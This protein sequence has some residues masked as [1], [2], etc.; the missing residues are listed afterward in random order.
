MNDIKIKKPLK[1]GWGNKRCFVIAAPEKS[2]R[3]LHEDY[4][5]LLFK[6]KNTLRQ[7]QWPLI[8]DWLKRYFDQNRN[9]RKAKNKFIVGF[10]KA[11]KVSENVKG[12]QD[13]NPLILTFSSTVK[14]I[15]GRLL[16]SIACFRLFWRVNILNCWYTT[17]K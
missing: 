7:D 11:W 5:P 17:T 15:P 14:I 9:D 8:E 6:M 3:P 12:W 16:P 2:G 1:L 13:T 4:V 10:F